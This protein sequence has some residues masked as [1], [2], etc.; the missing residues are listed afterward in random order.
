MAAVM[1]WHTGAA[2]SLDQQGACLPPPD[3]LS[4]RSG[5]PSTDLILQLLYYRP[6]LSLK[7]DHVVVE[8]KL[9]RLINFMI[10]FRLIS[11]NHCQSLRASGHPQATNH[12]RLL[13][14]AG[15]FPPPAEFYIKGY[16]LIYQA[17]LHRLLIT[18]F[19]ISGNRLPNWL[20]VTQIIDPMQL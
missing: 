7:K 5:F 14:R 18:P 13:R 15:S 16:Q 9:T 12:C 11:I 4:W 19:L 6:H 10:S 20:P 3:P 2:V 1:S 17:F 8:S